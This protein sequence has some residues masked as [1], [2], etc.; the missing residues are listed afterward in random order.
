MLA[1]FQSKY[2]QG[3]LIA[4][5]LQIHHGKYIVRASI[6]IEGITRATGMAA[7]EILED[8]EDRARSRA[9]MVLGIT[10]S[11][12]ESRVVSPEPIK[13]LQPN[14]SPTTTGLNQSAYSAAF[15]KSSLPE[16][17]P[18]SPA[19]LPVTANQTKDEV[20]NQ[21][22][23]QRFVIHNQQE[24]L[25]DTLSKDIGDRF[26]TPHKQET[27]FDS[28]TLDEGDRSVIH[29]QQETLLDTSSQDIGDCFVSPSKQETQFDSPTL[30]EGDRSASPSKQET[31]FDSPTLDEG[32]HFATANKQETQFDT[33]LENL[34]MQASSKAENQSFTE[35]S[36]SN[37]TPFPSRTSSSQDNV[38]TQTTTA[39][40]RKKKSEPID[41]SD[42]I[43]KIGVEMQ[44]LGWTTEQ[45]RDYLINTYG[46]RSRHLLTP[47]ELKS[48]LKHLESQP[49]PIDPLAGF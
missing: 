44:R 17:S 6:Q 32:D 22:I 19:V 2:P 21:D 33:S 31:Q 1:Q 35:N 36:P 8:A 41:Q 43:A 5:L 46:K 12:Q 49:T 27:Q 25:L 13:Q 29:N 23:G 7:S 10:E 37:V 38:G 26:A 40:K 45:G 42:D 48:F 30:D 47:D 16:A 24:T 11:S 34:G 9:L 4:E 20:E 18:V 14:P 15:N 39:A 3:S 28:P